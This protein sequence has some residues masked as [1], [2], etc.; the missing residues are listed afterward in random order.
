MFTGLIQELGKIRKISKENEGIRLEIEA[1]KVIE[2]AVLGDS[3]AV[4]GVCL[5]VTALGEEFFS[6]DVMN[7]TVSRTTFKNLLPGTTVN[8]EKSLTLQSALGG[9]LVLGDVEAVAKIL[10]FT[11]DGFSLRVRFSLPPEWNR[12]IVKKGRITVDGASLTVCDESPGEFSVSLIPHTI[13]NIRL[14]QQK[15]GD[16]VNIETDIIAKYTEKLLSPQKKEL[17]SSFLQEHGFWK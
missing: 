14:G 12:Y 13:E 4:N 6:A 16:E 2:G 9:H 5:T 3:I 8:L 7:E 10:S 1:K 15:A 11:P 17:D